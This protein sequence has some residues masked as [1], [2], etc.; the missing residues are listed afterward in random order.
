MILTSY[1]SL[2][3]SFILQVPE[4]HFPISY[5]IIPSLQG[6]WVLPKK[7]IQ[8]LCNCNFYLKL[9]FYLLFLYLLCKK[10]GRFWFRVFRFW[11]VCEVAQSCPALCDLMD[12]SPSGSSVHGILQARILEWVAISFSRGSSQTRDQTQV[13][14]IAGRCFILWANREVPPKSKC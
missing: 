6:L 3:Y 2:V 1:F 13:S 14:C 4:L 9:C 12:C 5:E 8:S 11:C 10:I 7:N